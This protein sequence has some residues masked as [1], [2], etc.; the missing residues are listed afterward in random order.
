MSCVHKF[1]ILPLNLKSKLSTR[2]RSFWF[3]CLKAFPFE[4]VSL[5]FNP[6]WGRDLLIMK[7]ADNVAFLKKNTLKNHWLESFFDR[8]LILALL[9]VWLRR[10]Q[11]K[12]WSNNIQSGSFNTQTRANCWCLL[13]YGAGFVAPRN[14]FSL[15]T[16]PTWLCS[17]KKTY[18]H[19]L[20]FSSE[21]V[22]RV[23]F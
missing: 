7:H 21:Q 16:H 15:T 14:V 19:F 20:I 10:V 5:S 23:V 3:L 2:K 8:T 13:L 12:R 6:R 11:H 17:N 9:E 22:P 4:N 1:D 18:E